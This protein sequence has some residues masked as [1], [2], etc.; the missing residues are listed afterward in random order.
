MRILISRA[1]ENTASSPGL[2]H[3]G[4]RAEKAQSHEECQIWASGPGYLHISMVLFQRR[5]SKVSQCSMLHTHIMPFYSIWIFTASIFSLSSRDAT[6]MMV[7][8]FELGRTSNVKCQ[9][10]CHGGLIHWELSKCTNDQWLVH[11]TLIV[12]KRTYLLETELT[13]IWS[14]MTRNTILKKKHTKRHL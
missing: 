13:R 3:R 9:T 1:C 12:M 6:Y 4:T 2:L 11:S 8:F 14:N 5:F 10:S 7:P